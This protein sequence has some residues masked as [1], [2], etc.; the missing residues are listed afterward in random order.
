MNKPILSKQAFWDVD[1]EKID[2]QKNALDILERV[3]N[4]GSFEDFKSLC[5]Y[6][7]DNRICE[8]IIHSKCL[9]DREINFCCVVFNLKPIDFKYR[10]KTKEAIT[11]PKSLYN[12]D[13]LN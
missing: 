10:K 7:G 6:Y 8:T 1:M 2:Y 13:Y 11:S 9:D 12:S 3:I 5:N 4:K